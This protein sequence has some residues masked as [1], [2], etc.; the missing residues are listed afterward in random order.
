[1]EAT[2]VRELE[3]SLFEVVRPLLAGL[4][5]GGSIVR[6]IVQGTHTGRIFVDRLP[7]PESALVWGRGGFHCVAGRADHGAFNAGWCDLLFG[8]LETRSCWI[9]PF[10]MG[11]WRPVLDGLLGQ[12]SARK[13]MKSFRFREDRYRAS[14][15]GKESLPSGCQLRHLDRDL[16][17]RAGEELHPLIQ[18]MWDAPERFASSGFGYCVLDADSRL[19]SVCYAAF[20]GGDEYEVGIMTAEQ[21]RRRGFASAAARGFIDECLSRQARPGWH[22]LTE[23]EASCALAR[24]LGFEPDL[25]FPI[26]RWTRRD[27]RTLPPLT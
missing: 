1:M 2:G 14:R 25:K 21:Y 3:P 11:S 22:C 27:D 4:S 7:D 18:R 23:N 26:Y 20:V 9:F 8:T 19:A 16:F 10:P 17:V 15:E 13:T 24:K 6:S 5:Y 12:R